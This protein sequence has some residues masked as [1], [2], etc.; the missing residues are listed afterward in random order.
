MLNSCKLGILVFLVCCFWAKPV[1]LWS[2]KVPLF[3]EDFGNWKLAKGDWVVALKLAE[4][5]W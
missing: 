3:C 1:W 4:W 5:V 2:S